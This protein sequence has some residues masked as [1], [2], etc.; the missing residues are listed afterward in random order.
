MI[1]PI[2]RQIIIPLILCSRRNLLRTP[3]RFEAAA[4]KTIDNLRAINHLVLE[5]TMHLMQRAKSSYIQIYLLRLN[6]PNRQSNLRN[7]IGC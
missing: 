3:A 2:L 4:T 1:K 6:K 7:I 5:L